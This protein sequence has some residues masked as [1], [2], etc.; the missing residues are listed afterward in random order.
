MDQNCV[1]P[2]QIRLRDQLQN[3]GPWSSAG[4]RGESGAPGF[5]QCEGLRGRSLVEHPAG[6]HTETQYQD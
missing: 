3:P 2:K 5:L 4:L 1:V 6:R